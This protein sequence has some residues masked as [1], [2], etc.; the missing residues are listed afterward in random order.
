MKK[1]KKFAQEDLNDIDLANTFVLFT[2]EPIKVWK[3]G[4]MF[5]ELGFALAHN[6]E[7]IIVG[8]RENVFCYL[9]QIRCF[10]TWNDFLKTCL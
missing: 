3:A 7:I 8:P 6:K 2:D 4:G 10:E 9:S 1:A 5:V